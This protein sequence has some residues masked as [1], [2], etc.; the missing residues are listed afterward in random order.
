MFRRLLLPIG[1]TCVSLIPSDPI[2]TCSCPF[3][4]ATC[5]SQTLLSAVACTLPRC[6]SSYAQKHT[7]S[8]LE[9]FSGA[10][11]STCSSSLGGSVP[12]GTASACQHLQLSHDSYPQVTPA[13]ASTPY[14]VMQA[15]N[16]EHKNVSAALSL[17][18]VSL[19]EPIYLSLESN[20]ASYLMRSNSGVF[21]VNTNTGVRREHAGSTADHHT[22]IRATVETSQFMNR[23]YDTAH[24]LQNT[25]ENCSVNLYADPL[26]Y[27]SSSDQ[28]VKKKYIRF[29]YVRPEAGP[30]S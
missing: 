16:L 12:G 29:N 2:G 30:K 9:L 24:E 28:L 11:C 8:D 21:L 17:P 20:Y 4:S 6:V 26:R 14:T 27:L 15:Q 23:H 22:A 18:R 1:Q 5:S 7:H 25:F 13:V 19:T 3:R 10:V